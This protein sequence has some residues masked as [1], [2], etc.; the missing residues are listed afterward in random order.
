LLQDTSRR[1][2]A[3][4]ASAAP[5]A[6][7]PPAGHTPPGGWVAP[8]SRPEA[9]PAATQPPVASKPVASKA[10]GSKPAARKRGRDPLW[11]RLMVVLGA[12]LMMASGG[13]IVGGKVMIGQYSGAI[14]QRDLLGNAGVS[15][16]SIDGP[17][18]ILLVGIDARPNSNELTR[19][20]SIIIAHINAKHDQAFLMSIP[21][22]LAVRIPAY[23][24]TG[25]KGGTEKINAAFAFGS[26]GKGG[27]EGG[28]ELLALTIQQSVAPGIRFDGGAIVD[29]GGFQ[30]LVNALGGVDMC[31]DQRV[32][33]IHVGTDRKGKF[34]SPDRGG[35]PVVYEPGC[36][37][38]EPWQALDY[39][40][41]RHLPNG[42]YDRA[43]HQQQFVKAM[44]K[45]AK[46]QGIAT[47]PIKLNNVMTAAGKALTV[48]KN[49][50][51]IEDWLFTL[52]SVI[53]NDPVMLKTNAGKINSVRVGSE[54][55]ESLT[56]ESR[57]MFQAATADTLDQ[58]VMAN[59]T[60]V[61]TDG[62]IG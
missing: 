16:V 23:A 55:A 46:K 39:V 31:I 9:W 53:N 50:V 34:L 13:A 41:Q 10:V 45:E 27:R 56:P 42:D 1:Q 17:L 48:D 7:A 38:L 12:L 26:Q 33:S 60:F 18:N 44:V 11:A 22:D 21:R 6:P 19:S 58:F 52:S 4:G 62:S 32:S 43:R 30:A 54:E 2:P 25:Y 57:A 3:R 49:G 35:K 40:R 51:K 47:N 61:A 24:K 8:A 29:F 15:H 14:E 59:P 37:R 5:F 28:V 36:Q 20:D